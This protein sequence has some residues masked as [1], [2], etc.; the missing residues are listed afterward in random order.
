MVK[1]I[2]GILILVAGVVMILY[3]NYIFE[4][5]GEGKGKIARAEQQMQTGKEL[6][7]F[8][9]A[10]VTESPIVQGVGE[11]VS[12]SIQQK[13]NEGKATIAYYEKVATGLKWGGWAAIIVGAILFLFSF[14][15]GKKKR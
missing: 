8:A 2:L 5:I 11:H 14:A 9:P 13:I 6:F 12:S 15:G 4:Q 10:Q 1:R 7:S 3:S